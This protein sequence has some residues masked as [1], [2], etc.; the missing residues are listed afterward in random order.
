MGWIQRVGNLWRRGISAEHEEELEYHL[1][2]SAE[3]KVDAGMTAEEARLAA[4]RRF[5]NVTSVKEEM[6]EADLFTFVESVG[7]DVRFAA[8][9]LAK[10]PGFTAIAVLGLAVGIGVNTAVFTAYK[11]LVLQP[12]DA[13]DPGELVNIYR[14]T[15]HDP[16][17]QRFSY[18][19]FE[20]YR[21][22]NRVFSG[23]V[24]TTGDELALTGRRG[25]RE[26]GAVDR[27]RAGGRVRVPVSEPDAWRG[28]V[29]ERRRRVGELFFG[30]GSTGA[31]GA[32]ISAAG[33][34]GTGRSSGRAARAKI[35]GNGALAG[36]LRCWGRR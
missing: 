1:S 28:G 26:S 14:S 9:M 7:R 35:I 16:Y 31:A 20:F 36:T 29:C 12:L 11:A 4:R 33:R 3:T 8:R 5:G 34:A 10:H 21:D 32:G 13:K 22:H 27:E 2:R 6:R 25:D 17:E 15:S 18:P 30:A 23:V 24:A 19:D